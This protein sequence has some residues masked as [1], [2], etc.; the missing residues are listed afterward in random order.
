MITAWAIDI[1]EPKEITE[2][3]GN[4]GPGDQ[5]EPNRFGQGR[6]RGEKA[7][8]PG[9]VEIHQRIHDFAEDDLL[10][11]RLGIQRLAPPPN[12]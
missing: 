7:L 3:D 8:A 6:A 1:P 4:H 12:L 11:L 9:I 2:P 10:A 5:G